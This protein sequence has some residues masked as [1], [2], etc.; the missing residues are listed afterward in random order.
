VT[1]VTEN[2]EAVGSR[3]A[4]LRSVGVDVVRMPVT[5]WTARL[6]VRPSPALASAVRA[7]DVVHIHGVWEHVLHEAAAA[8]HAAGVPYVIRGCGMLDEWALRRKPLKKR[9]YIALRLGGI[10]ERAAAL[11]CTSQMEADSTGRLNLR[12]PPFILEPNGIMTAEFEPLPAYGGFRA[13]LGIGE[14][15]LIVF[16]GRVHPGKGVEYLLP[17][18]DLLRTR[19]PVVAIVGPDA[20]PFAT[21]MKGLAAA[22]APG[23]RVVFTGMMRGRER[24]APLV[25]ADVFALPSEHE[26]FGVS[27]IEALAAGCPVVVSDQVSLGQEVVSQGVGTSTTLAPAAIAAALDDWLA[28]SRSIPRPFAAARRYAF[29]TFDWC[30]ISERWLAHYARLAG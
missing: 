28:R 26:N 1:I 10:L 18:L 24:I 22:V 6:A 16:L 11:H 9:L 3:E 20:S 27:V 5:S 14:R 13:A 19:D 12:F 25:D 23:V 7:S 29:D 4:N 2:N 17:A 15:P 30:R 8:A 21:Q